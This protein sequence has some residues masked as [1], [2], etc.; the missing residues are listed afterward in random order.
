[1]V[2]V[3]YHHYF[4]VYRCAWKKGKQ[5]SLF[6][7]CNLSH[8]RRTQVLCRF[9]T[10]LQWHFQLISPRP[11]SASKMST[12]PPS[13]L[14]KGTFVYTRETPLGVNYRSHH[15]LIWNPRSVRHLLYY[16]D[17]FNDIIWEMCQLEIHIIVQTFWKYSR[18]KTSTL[19]PWTQC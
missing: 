4:L 19:I 10:T 2:G 15:C 5:L 7:A 17:H 14:I 13:Q 6:L 1:V 16:C 3:R 8:F 11:V 9:C 12:Y 18:P